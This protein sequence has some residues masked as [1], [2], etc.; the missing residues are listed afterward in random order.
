MIAA[1][2]IHATSNLLIQDNVAFHINGHAFYLEDGVEEHNWF[3]SN[4]AAYVHVIGAPASGALQ[5]G[6]MSYQVPAA[7]CCSPL[8]SQ[9]IRFCNPWSSIFNCISK[10]R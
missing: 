2:A 1:V 4:L 5:E 8:A 9:C 6:S 10:T 3:E 7:A